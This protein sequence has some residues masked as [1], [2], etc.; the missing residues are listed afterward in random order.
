MEGAVASS[1][2]AAPAAS[3]QVF[4][5][6]VK[7]FNPTK[8]WGFVESPES[9]Q[10][11]G[12]DVFLLKSELKGAIGV[13][14]GDKVQF[15][16]VQGPRGIQATNVRVLSPGSGE[17]EQTF[18][19][20]IKGFDPQKGW[21][22]IACELAH[23]SYGKD[24]FVTSKQIPGGAVPE[25]T[26]V[27]FLVRM[28]DK[29]PVAQDVKIIGMPTGVAPGGAKGGAWGAMGKGLLPPAMAWGLQQPPWAALPPPPWGKGS[30]P[31]AASIP[32][33]GAPYGGP[34]WGGAPM[35]GAGFQQWGS[36]AKKDPGEE[37]LFFGT[38]KGVNAEKGWG[39]ID[40]EA[41]KKIYGKDMFIMRSSLEALAGAQQGAP[42]QVGLVV[43][44]N[45]AQG[46]KGPHAV[47]VAPFTGQ[48]AA[49]QT[50]TGAIKSFSETK[51]WGFIESGLARQ[52]YGQD[53]FLHKKELN[54]SMTTISV[55][56]EVQ[57]SVD[58][59]SG[60]PAAKS[61]AV[62][63]SNSAQGGG[64]AAGAATAPASY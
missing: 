51:G 39:H 22:F 32:Q 38:L 9:Q 25:G 49:G 40:C 17:A 64:V 1:A 42:A 19:G 5:G 15:C 34:P 45:V 18:F 27:Q 52:L 23:E 3:D 56:D 10:I 44:F 26:Q 48:H 31:W 62:I 47:N 4:I 59:T 30:P 35:W 21:G 63:P 58:I 37:E 14:K 57:F 55:G 33:Y 36:S 54:G 28:E 41:L 61:V 2:S 16:V 7:S 24:V 12:S 60:R 11:Y 53:V 20:T 46:P 6:S 13:S 50:F 8:G 43:Q 29:G